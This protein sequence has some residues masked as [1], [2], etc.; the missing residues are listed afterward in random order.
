MFYRGFVKQ[1]IIWF[2]IICGEEGQELKASDL[3]LLRDLHAVAEAEYQPAVGVDRDVV[4]R[5]GPERI[6]IMR[7]EGGLSNP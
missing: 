5:S 2:H 7:I 6:A 1:P 3:H 4:H